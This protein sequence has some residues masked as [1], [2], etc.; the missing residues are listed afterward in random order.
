MRQ[1]AIALNDWDANNGRL[2]PPAIY[3]KD[4]KPLLSWRVLILPYLEEDV[5]LHLDEPWDSPYNLALLPRMPRVYRATY[6]PKDE[7]L[8]AASSTFCQ[9]FTGPGTAFEGRDGVRLADFGAPLDSVILVA[10]ASKPVPWTKPE[11]IE[12]S[13]DQPL[14]A[15]GGV[16]VGGGRFSL[17]G[18]N[19]KKGCCAAL[20]DGHVAFVEPTMAGAHLRRAIKRDEGNRSGNWK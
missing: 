7:E 1:I 4:G 19:R 5:P 3:D 20:A 18:E 15:L 12:Y 11:D 6:F 10:E 16:F 8:P 9:V 14:P 2:P 13:D 17:F